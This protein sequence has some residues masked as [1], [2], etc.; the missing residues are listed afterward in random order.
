MNFDLSDIP[1]KSAV[2]VFEFLDTLLEKEDLSPDYFREKINKFSIEEKY[3]IYLYAS[4]YYTIRGERVS[5]LDK[6]IKKIEEKYSLDDASEYLSKINENAPKIL[7]I[8]NDKKIED[9][10]TEFKNS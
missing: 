6:W 9:L 1:I 2:K 4:K 5:Y 3:F 8:T 10:Q 7:K